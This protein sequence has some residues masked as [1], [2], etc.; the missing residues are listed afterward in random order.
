MKER[1]KLL[2]SSNVRGAELLISERDL[3]S[4]VN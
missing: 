1:R 3:R 2:G 4:A